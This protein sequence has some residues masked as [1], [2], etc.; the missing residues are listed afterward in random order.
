MLCQRC[1]TREALSR[2]DAPVTCH[3]FGEIEGRFCADCVLE[4]Q[5]PY[6]EQL[7]RSI[8]ER[9]PQLSDADLAAFPDQMLK[10]TLCLPIPGAA[11]ELARSG[12]REDGLSQRLTEGR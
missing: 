2:E 3:L 11:G 12:G 7:R 4:L 8:A 1:Q 5:R 9:A 6:E 10:F